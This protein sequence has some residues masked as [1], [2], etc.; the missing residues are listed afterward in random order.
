METDTQKVVQTKDMNYVEE[1]SYRFFR[2]GID[3]TTSELDALLPLPPPFPFRFNPPQLNDGVV[4]RCDDTTRIVTVDF[5]NVSTIDWE[6]KLYYSH[7]LER[8]DILLLSEGLL[9]GSIGD[10]RLF[11]KGLSSDMGPVPLKLFREFRAI[12]QGGF[13]KFKERTDEHIS[14][15]VTD[16]VRYLELFYG[17]NNDE[18]FSYTNENGTTISISNV[19]DVVFYLLDVDMSQKLS[20]FDQDFKEAFKMKEILPGGE[21][22]LLNYVSTD[23]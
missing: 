13:R 11:L 15:T 18:P 17:D 6:H 20:H 19:K 2:T 21:W 23:S 8:D 16:Y 1:L 4:W 5:T 12:K 7:L 3:Y 9:P 10:V 14:M 22:C